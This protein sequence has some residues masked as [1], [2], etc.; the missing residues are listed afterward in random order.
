[1]ESI[2]EYPYYEDVSREPSREKDSENKRTQIKSREKSRGTPVYDTVATPTSGRAKEANVTNKAA[3]DVYAIQ[4][5][6]QALRD[7]DRRKLTRV[8]TA[9]FR[10]LSGTPSDQWMPSVLSH[11]SQKLPQQKADRPPAESRATASRKSVRSE[12]S[13]HLVGYSLP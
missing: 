9:Q 4:K 1:M 8:G 5:L 10:P 6:K 7:K 12:K 11:K 13:L 2:S 3:E